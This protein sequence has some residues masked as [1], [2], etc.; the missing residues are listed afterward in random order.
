MAAV[1]LISTTAFVRAQDSAAPVPVHAPLDAFSTTVSELPAIPFADA[2]TSALP[3]IPFADGRT[4]SPEAALTVGPALPIRAGR[5]VGSA[6]N[7]SAAAKP[8]PA[9]NSS[10]DVIAPPRGLRGRR[11]AWRSSCPPDP[12]SSECGGGHLAGEGIETE[13]PKKTGTG[14]WI[15]L[16]LVVAALFTSIARYRSRMPKRYPITRDANLPLDPGPVPARSPD[17]SS[18]IESGEGGENSPDRLRRARKSVLP[19]SAAERQKE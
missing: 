4:S 1:A 9:Q 17:R 5:S 16:G 8:A 7:P 13:F 12:G 3:A 15:L 14:G 18:S 6:A 10:V 11:E 19:L 2:R